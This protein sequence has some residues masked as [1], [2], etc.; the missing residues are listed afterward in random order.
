M[1]LET[2]GEMGGAELA[3]RRADDRGHAAAAYNLGLLLAN[4]GELD[5]AAEAFRRAESRGHEE[6][7]RMAHQAL[8]ELR[9][10]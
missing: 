3:Y 5:E 7:S 10:D 8:A 9:G 1:V 6:V 2:R 4:R